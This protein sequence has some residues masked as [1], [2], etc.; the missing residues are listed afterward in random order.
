[1]DRK[2]KKAIREHYCEC[3]GRKIYPGMAYIWQVHTV[4][5]LHTPHKLHV[6]CDA[7]V[8]MVG[9]ETYLPDSKRYALLRHW[10]EENVCGKCPDSE[11]CDQSEVYSCPSVLLDVL[12]PT[13]AAAAIESITALYEREGG[14]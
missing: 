14:E 5:G 4:K 9:R 2:Q 11:N 7:L 8:E 10:L 6:H 1:M 3:C 13:Y 12:P